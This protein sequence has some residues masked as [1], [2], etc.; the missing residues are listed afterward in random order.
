MFLFSKTGS[1]LLS[2]QTVLGID[3]AIPG[4]QK[5]DDKLKKL[6]DMVSFWII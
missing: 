3:K 2:L 1:L 6:V 4:S 5:L